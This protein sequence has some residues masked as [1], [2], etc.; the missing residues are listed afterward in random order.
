MAPR[1]P[2]G[3]AGIVAIYDREQAD[4]VNATL[5]NAAKKSTAQVD[6]GSAKQLKAALAEAQ[7]GTSTRQLFS[8]DDMDSSYT[9]C[10]PIGGSSV[11]ERDGQRGAVGGADHRRENAC[12]VG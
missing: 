3:S 2:R 5:I 11:R 8:F 1:S 9:R 10:P 7:A 6:G 4:T 12:G